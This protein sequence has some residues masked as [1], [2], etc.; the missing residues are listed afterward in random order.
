MSLPAH[1][2]ST[3]KIYKFTVI[4]KLRGEVVTPRIRQILAMKRKGSLSPR[5][6]LSAIILQ[7]DP[8][9][10]TIH[11]CLIFLFLAACTPVRPIVKIG[12][13]APFEGLYRESGYAALAAMRQAIDECT[14]ATLEVIPVALDDSGDPAQAQRAA[15]KLLVD[16]AVDAIIGPL[17]LDAVPAV[18]A[19]MTKATEI[20]WLIPAL[21]APEGGFAS[22]QTSDWLEAQ[23]ELVARESSAPRILLLGL[24]S[25]W[26]L[27][28]NTATP[29]LRID[30]LETIAAGDAILWLGPPDV[31]ARWF[32]ALRDQQP[33]VDFW[34]GSQAGVDVFV[35]HA[36]DLHGAHWLLWTD[37][38]YNRWSQSTAPATQMANATSFDVTPYLT[39]RA[40]CNAL[41]ALV[42][43]PS[44]ATVTWELQSRVI[45]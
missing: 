15:Q 8:Y 33:D 10:V 26:E 30:D 38:N 4:N 14:P 6:G 35:A 5:R 23:V 12:L 39:Y 44:G 17:L 3:N 36:T 42:D 13:I 11:I 19:V 40:T 1:W 32:A 2:L 16:P 41:A 18:T 28:L 31:G 9:G 29:V 20:P 45:E 21:V 37:V 34:L 7:R 43:S 24:P 22:L 27:P 25:D